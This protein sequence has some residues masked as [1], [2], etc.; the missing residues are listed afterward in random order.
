MWQQLYSQ[1]PCI[2]EIQQARYILVHGQPHDIQL[3]GF[4]DAS[5]RYYGCA[6]YVR[7]TNSKNHTE[8]HLLCSKSKVAPIKKVTLP[9]LELCAALLLARLMSKVIPVLNLK[10]SNTF[11]WT[12]SRIVSAWLASP[13]SRWK[14]F[15]GNRVGEIQ[16]VSSL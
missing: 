1:L 6:I 10:I 8:T 12:D 14:P 9:R 2:N 16:E 15:I 5:E 3:H 13:A 7:S 11:Y 4:S